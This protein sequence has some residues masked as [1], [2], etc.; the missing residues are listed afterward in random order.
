MTVRKE[1]DYDILGNVLTTT[2]NIGEFTDVSIEELS[3]PAIHADLLA[4][5]K[6][7]TTGK[8]PSN[9]VI[10]FSREIILASGLVMKLAGNAM[11]SVKQFDAIKADREA[12]EAKEAYDSLTPAQKRLFDSLNTKVKKK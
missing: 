6:S 10:T 1:M 11:I 12:R 2:I 4:K 9:L 3:D 7:E 8:A 5:D